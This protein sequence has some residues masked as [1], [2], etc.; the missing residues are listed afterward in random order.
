MKP[1]N[2]Q[3][4]RRTAVKTVE[5]C[6]GVEA[7]V[8]F[9]SRARGTA[10][11][12]SDWDVAVLS[13]AD[14]AVEQSA[15]RLLGEH[16]RVNAIVLRPEAIEEYRD[17]ATRLEAVIARQGRL[18]A[19]NW[20][21]P[22]C[23]MEYLDMEPDEFRKDLEVA[24][25]DIE[26][27]V[28]QLCNAALDRDEYV[29]NLVELSQQAAEAVAKSIVAGHGLTPITTHELNELATQLENAYRGRRGGEAR[30]LFA[31]ALRDLNGNT[32][33]AH[34]A[35]YAGVRVEEPADTVERLL[36]VQ[37]LQTRWIRSCAEQHPDMRAPAKALGQ[38]IA[39]AAKRLERREH[40]LQDTWLDGPRAALLSRL[41][42]TTF[43]GIAPAV[44]AETRLWGEEG[45]SIAKEWDGA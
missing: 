11:P 20:S 25:R 3:L 34:G 13:R 23:R 1:T 2:Y 31:R 36:R 43:D 6:P 40:P 24:I 45:E 35:R 17:R 44:Q 12:K 14:S 16:E 9:G 38:R 22:Q 33:A 41:R 32:R 21:R 27:A 10:H 26:N 4:L 15:C 30:R 7:V 39:T 8:L 5:T 29:P 18:L 28:T 19:G 37:R 42:L